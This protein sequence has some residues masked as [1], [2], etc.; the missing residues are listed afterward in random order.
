MP[1]WLRLIAIWPAIL[2]IYLEL[3]ILTAVAIMFSSFSTPALSALLTFFVFI[4]GHFSASLR[5]LAEDLGTKP[6]KYFFNTIYYLLPNLSHFSFATETS[7]GVAAPAAMIGGDIAYAV[8][9]NIILLTITIFVFS[10][11]NFK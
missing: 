9:Y 10:R 3:T 8:V 4:I 2:L 6:A 5:Q 1:I 7:N 11:R